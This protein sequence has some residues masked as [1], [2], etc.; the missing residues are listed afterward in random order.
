[1]WLTVVGL[2]REIN[3]E[4]DEGCAEEGFQLAGVK[5]GKDGKGGSEVL[6]VGIVVSIFEMDQN[7]D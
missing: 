4:H 7:W 2:N 6:V 3:E 1:M 5:L